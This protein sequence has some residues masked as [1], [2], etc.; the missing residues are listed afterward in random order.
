MTVHRFHRLEQQ[1]SA[2]K[3]N[4]RRKSRELLQAT[5]VALPLMAPASAPAVMV[6]GSIDEGPFVE[7]DTVTITL[8]V[9]SSTVSNVNGDFDVDGVNVPS[10]SP[11][12]AAFPSSHN[13]SAIQDGNFFWTASG[14]LD[15][16]GDQG[17]AWSADGS[18]EVANVA[19]TVESATLNGTNGNLEVPEGT[20]VLADATS[21]DPGADDHAY[22]IDG[23]SAGT[24]I[25][26]T[27]TR[28]SQPVD[29]TKYQDGAY[30]INYDVTDDDETTSTNHTLT[31][32]NVAPT[33][34]SATLNGTNDNLEVPEGTQVLAAATS[35]DPGA[36]DH[37][38]TIAGQSGGTDIS[39]T[40]TRS[41]TDVDVTQTNDGL[42]TID[43]SV[44]DDD[45][46]TMTSRTLTVTNVAPTVESATLDGT[47]GDIEV[48]EGATVTAAMTSSD[49]GADPQAYTI[50]GAA[51]GTDNS[52]SGTRV[53]GD[54][55]ISRADEEV[56]LVE[57][58]VADDDTSS[59]IF[60]TLTFV[61]AAP[62]FTTAPGDSTLDFEVSA[63]YA[64]AAAA[65]DAGVNDVLTYSWDRDGDGQYDE[66]NMTGM[67]EYDY[68]QLPGVSDGVLTLALQ[69]SDGDGGF[70]TR[71]FLLTLQN[72][73][74][75]EA[76]QW[77]MF[78]VL[79]VGA[80]GVS[81]WRRFGDR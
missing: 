75:P 4:V 28:S 60:R 22:T 50:G 78:G 81:L 5:V 77:L 64:L 29:I 66:S 41:S 3:R 56:V 27:G 44:M 48:F 1:L 10:G 79:I 70:D 68:S 58:V 72:S 55:G 25:S 61:N 8:S 51:A 57:F 30:T 14:S 76:H 21:T 54:V 26:Q 38:Y 20:Q 42:F 23:Q 9:D 46:S 17:H 15:E 39:Q 12:V 80:G 71:S 52:L 40:G 11:N 33:I 35:T 53:S 47:N 59:S 13:Y 36:D 74:V 32:T 24:D 7:G 31:V 65:S 63:V 37:A 6:T 67:F 19:P 34:E 73:A 2:A 16:E 45:E 18:F 62:T 69:V 43:Y 49:P